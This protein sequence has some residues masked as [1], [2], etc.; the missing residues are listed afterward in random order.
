MRYVFIIALFAFTPNI[1]QAVPPPEFISVAWPAFWQI[2]GI[3]F[4]LLSGVWFWL[5]QFM[6]MHSLGVTVIIII[7]AA[8]IVAFA[9]FK[10]TSIIE[11]EQVLQAALLREPIETLETTDFTQTLKDF[12]N[13]YF[14]PLEEVKAAPEA[15]SP[16]TLQ[17]LIDD[18][19]LF[20]SSSFAKKYGTQN[21][22]L[23][24]ETI[25]LDVRYHKAFDQGH[26]KNAIL[27]D[28]FNIDYESLP[29]TK[30]DHVVAYCHTGYTSLA[31]VVALRE[32]GYNADYLIGGILTIDPKIWEG[33]LPD[34]FLEYT[35]LLTLLTTDEVVDAIDNKN[36]LFVDVRNRELFEQNHLPGAVNI[37]LAQMTHLEA[38]SLIRAL[39]E[40]RK[41]IVPCSE[42]LSCF[43][44]LIL[45]YILFVNDRPFMGRYTVPEEFPR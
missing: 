38:D 8:G 31:A 41:V 12:S 22:G 15:E 7:V 23:T 13:Y 24:S 20:S 28:P 26:I 33:E 36:A 11:E 4:V 32:A 44:G 25:Y 18:R 5:K 1:S 29:F 9:S 35:A 6:K 17:A 37:P 10:K 43:Q 45:S 14:I 2:V 27:F 21:D 39:P 40:D 16:E 30:D 3:G 42:R 19:N 34:I